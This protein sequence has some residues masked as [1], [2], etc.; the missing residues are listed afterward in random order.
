MMTLTRLPEEIHGSG[1]GWPDAA[2]S[3]GPGFCLDRTTLTSTNTEERHEA[4]ADYPGPAGRMRKRA[5]SDDGLA[6]RRWKH[7]N[8]DLAGSNA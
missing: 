1:C 7:S 4:L 6:T 8:I 2:C 3:I 5:C